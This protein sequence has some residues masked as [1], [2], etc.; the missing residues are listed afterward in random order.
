MGMGAGMGGIF[1]IGAM[2]MALSSSVAM[3]SFMMY[4]VQA[5]NSMLNRAGR[6]A[7]EAAKG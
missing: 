2:G 1:G 4:L 5:Q 6:A 7:D 3:L